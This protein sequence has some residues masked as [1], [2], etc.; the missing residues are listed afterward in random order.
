MPQYVIERDIP[1]VGDMTDAQAREAVLRSMEVL[2]DLGDEIRWVR[3]FVVDNKIYCIYFAPDE[4][5]IRAHAERMGLPV[6]RISRV[7]QLLDPSAT[8]D[9]GALDVSRTG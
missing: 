6:D 3:S 2:E 8:P 4:T 9:P 5:L 1:G 7:K